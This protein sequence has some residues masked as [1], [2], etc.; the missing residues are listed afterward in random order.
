MFSL[1]TAIDERLAAL[2]HKKIKS[3]QEVSDNNI[4]KSH[5]EHSLQ[6]AGILNKNGEMINKVASS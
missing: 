3:K 5:I 1:Q 6:R 2:D 4:D